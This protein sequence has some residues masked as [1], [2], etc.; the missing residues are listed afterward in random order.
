MGVADHDR[1][2]VAVFDFDGTIADTFPLVLRLFTEHRTSKGLSAPSDADI[3]EL[4]SVD[5][6]KVFEKLNI[7]R[8]KVPFAIAIMRR[9]LRQVEHEIQPF[10]GVREILEQIVRRGWQL[11]VLSSNSTSTIRTFFR[12]HKLPQPRE[13][14]GGINFFGKE[15]RLRKLLAKHGLDCGKV[16]L[17]GD[18]TRDLHVGAVCGCRTIG[19]TWGFNLKEVLASARPD[20]LASTPDEL[21][22]ALERLL[23]GANHGKDNGR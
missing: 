15:P 2:R 19:V 13:V 14:A 9:K 22:D 21:A 12:H 17:I 16:V 11:Y 6:R 5:S 20:A 10:H 1:T 7:P 23:P 8:W 18:E 4:R 3:H